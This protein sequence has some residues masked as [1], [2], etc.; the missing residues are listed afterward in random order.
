MSGPVIVRG[1]DLSVE[2]VVEVSGGALVQL[3][4]A[5]LAEAEATFD[6][7]Q[8]WGDSSYPMYGVNTGFG[9]LIH[10]HI[11]PRFR[12]D[13]QDNLLRSHA[14]GAGVPFPEPVVRAIMVVR[15]NCLMKGY[16]GV[17]R[18]TLELMAALLNNKI[19]PIVP[20]QGSLGASG[21]L[22]PLSH[23][24]VTLIGDGRVVYNGQEMS[25][26]DAFDRTDLEPVT[27]GYKEGLALINGTSGMTGV[28]ALALVEAEQL[29]R[30]AVLASSVIVQLLRASSRPF[31]ERGH[32]LKNHSGQI[33][34]ASALRKLLEGSRLTRDHAAIAGSLRS[35]VANSTDVVDTGVY[36]QNAYSLRAIP[37]ILGPLAE[38]IQFARRIVTEEINSA[39][40]NPLFFDTPESAFHGGNF[41]GQYVATVCDFLNIGLTEL[42]VLIE[43]Q[44]DRLLDPARSG[45]LPAFLAHQD[46]GLYSG[47]EGAQ[48]LVTSLA[49]ENIDLAAPASIRSIPSNGGNQDVVSMGL[50]SAKKTR[51]LCD[52]LWTM[53]AYVLGA[54]RQASTFVDTE[55]LSPSTRSAVDL[56]AGVFEPYDDS[57]VLSYELARVR[58]LVTGADFGTFL[59]SE[60][61]LSV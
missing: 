25:A 28:A 54:C 1:D 36:L 51:K 40:D 16:S 12:T 34:V 20:D 19:A 26:R 46:S 11:P 58:G 60:V 15:L 33:A 13:L 14:A 61:L 2:A 7:V 56:I 3:D 50:I 48:Y 42:G 22:A 35:Q 45:G 8:V 37:Q 32:A 57:R 55:S 38:T 41:H 17:S 52:N 5:R 59:R 27:L 6:R 31:E 18:R 9:E 49:A 30:A 23:I 44:L 21:D 4:E 47:F 24:A 53:V 29:L 39:N 10:V 43:R